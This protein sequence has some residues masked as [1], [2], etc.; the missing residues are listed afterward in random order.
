MMY[1]VKLTVK[2]CFRVTPTMTFN[3]PGKMDI[4][5]TVWQDI[6]IE[7]LQNKDFARY[8]LNDILMNMIIF[9]PSEVSCRCT[10][11]F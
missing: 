2:L 1:K 8:L 6:A 3:R 7:N 5:P 11:D 9:V 10:C 4:K